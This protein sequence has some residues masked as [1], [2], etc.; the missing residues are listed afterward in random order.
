MMPRVTGT[1]LSVEILRI[2]P[3]MPIILCTGYDKKV[4]EKTAKELGIKGFIL[5]PADRKEL[6]ELVRNILDE[7]KTA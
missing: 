2:R 7:S 4:T 1:E 6:A 3:G 5:K